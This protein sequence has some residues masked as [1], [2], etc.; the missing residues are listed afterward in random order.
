MTGSHNNLFSKWTTR[1]QYAISIRPLLLLCIL[2]IGAPAILSGCH[3]INIPNDATLPPYE[4]RFTL[5]P[6]DI[7]QVQFRLHPELNIEQAVRPDGQISLHMVDEVE[8]EGMTPIQVDQKLTTMYREYLQD[9]VLTVTVNSEGTQRV[10][11]GGEVNR[12]GVIPL[13]GKVSVLEAI[14]EAGGFNR[15]HAADRRVIVYRESEN[16]RYAM[17]VNMREK[18]TTPGSDTMYLAPNDVVY[19]DRTKISQINQWIDQYI[20]QMFPRLGLVSI[21]GGL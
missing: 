12:P 3:S 13:T 2:S 17:N 21:S 4:Q 1:Q 20:S 9:P 16:K 10:F 11:V 8:V 19:V 7:V 5:S 18:L 6:G 14:V 15:H